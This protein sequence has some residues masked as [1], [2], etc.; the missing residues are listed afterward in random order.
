MRLTP[1]QI[2]N[3]I[4]VT[5]KGIPALVHVTTY[6]RVPPWRGSA[7]SCPSADDYYGYTELEY[8]LHDRKGYPAEW[9]ERKLDEDAEI[10]IE[11]E[12]LSA[13]KE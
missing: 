12:I 11:E 1:E 2:F 13:I 7:R 4:P 6:K 3:A 9:L 10:R 8:Q 5:V